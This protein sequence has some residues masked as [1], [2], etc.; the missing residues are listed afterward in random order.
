MMNHHNHLTA[1]GV[2]AVE[3]ALVSAVF[4]TILL[5]A[6]EMGRV[7]FIWNTAAEATRWGAR[8]A[9]VCDEGDEAVKDRMVQLLPNL[10]T[11]ANISVVSACAGGDC[12]VTVS[13]ES[14]IEVDTFIPFLPP[15]LLS[16]PS[17]T[18]TLTRESMQS[19][20]PGATG[21]ANP[22]CL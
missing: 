22:V 8:I 17:F 21:G 1:R 20:W 5:G 4:F 7:L 15:P 2:A 16:L 9:T 3:F 10:L 14:G 11:S 6:L 12:T 18:T 13:L 19:V